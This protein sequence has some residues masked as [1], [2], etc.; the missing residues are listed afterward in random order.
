M[1]KARALTR[2]LL[3]LAV[4]ASLAY[5]ATARATPPALVRAPAAPPVKKRNDARI[6]PEAASATLTEPA[7]A[8]SPA[9]TPVLIVAR[10]PWF[11]PWGGVGATAHFDSSFVESGT[12]YAAKTYYGVELAGGAHFLLTDSRR[13]VLG[14]RLQFPINNERLG[15]GVKLYRIQSLADVGW[16]IYPGQFDVIAHLGLSSI[17]GDSS[18]NTWRSRFTWTYGFS[19]LYHFATFAPHSTGAALEGTLLY[20]GQSDDDFLGFGNA[21]CTGFG[22]SSGSCATGIAPS[23]LQ[24][25][26]RFRYEF[27]L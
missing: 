4:A 18:S 23:Q 16:S 11:R 10:L 7:R 6:L 25:T 5:A 3:A 24:L 27:L 26:V 12:N 1:P 13:L 20:T 19:A 17:F 8:P 15:T 2:P 21:I 9:P 22:G 14:P